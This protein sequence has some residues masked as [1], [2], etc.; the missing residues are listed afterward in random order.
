I[1]TLAENPVKD[2]LH[3]LNL[4]DNMSILTDSK[5]T[6]T[7]HGRMKKPYSSP[8]FMANC[9]NTRYLKME[10]KDL[11]AEEAET[12]ANVW[13]DESVDVNS[14]AGGNPGFHK[15]HYDNPLLTKKTE[16]EP[17]IWD[18]GDEEEEYP[19]VNKYPSFIKEPI[20]LVKEESCPV[21]DN[22]NEE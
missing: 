6:P 13:D 11:P 3:K 10:V 4:H 22:D 16:S 19:F 20:V 7:K 1:Y 8:R 15:D 14:F 9:F 17:I 21:Y 2:I 18:I 12:E 5:V